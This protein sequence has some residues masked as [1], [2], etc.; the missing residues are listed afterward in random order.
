MT[1]KLCG[2][3]ELSQYGILDLFLTQ[4]ISGPENLNVELYKGDAIYALCLI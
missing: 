3:F 2:H 1:V 4:Y